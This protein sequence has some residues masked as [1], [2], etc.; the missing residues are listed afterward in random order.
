MINVT[1]LFVS[2][3]VT[4]IGSPLIGLLV[5]RYLG[6]HTY[7]QYASAVAVT[8][9]FGFICD[10]GVQQT[11]L[12]FGANAEFLGPVLK[13]GS[14]VS[15]VYTAITIAI[16]LLWMSIFPYDPLVKQIIA[17]QC[18]GL[19]R[20]PLLTL[21]TAGL[22]LKGKYGRIAFWN[23]STT[24]VQWAGTLATM[25]AGQSVIVL[26][27]I[28]IA[29]SIFLVLIMVVIE[30]R[31]LG[32]F[33]HPGL[34]PDAVSFLR[35]SWK[36]GTAG[37]MFQ[38]Y[39]K[40]DSAIL[41]AARPPLE[42]GQYSVA[43]RMAEMA[44]VI[45]GIVFNQVLYPK[46]FRWSQRD[47]E[48][49]RTFYRLT[50][51][52]IVILGVNVAAVMILFGRDLVRVLFRMDD[53]VI[54]VI[55]PT[56]ATGVMLHF[57]AAAPGAILTTDGHVGRKIWIQGSTAFMSLLLNLLLTPSFGA[58]AAAGVFA[59]SQL[60]L[61]VLYTR[62]LIRRTSF[63]VFDMRWRSIAFMAFVVGLL[64][65]GWTLLGMSWLVRGLSVV[66][67][68]SMSALTVWFIW[69]TEVERTEIRGFL[70]RPLRKWS[71]PRV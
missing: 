55:I 47:R 22:Q 35:E 61:G 41:S 8:G 37:A 58:V 5:V 56:L 2:R 69:L 1:L 42:I 21:V 50:T 30:G 14:L 17:I 70:W 71:A 29:I 62:E 7:G 52:L 60:M 26:T 44:N 27:S 6:P 64:L 67:I 57:W 48:K 59:L 15:L 33:E 23:L 12:R 28:P 24:L 43:M 40:G 39:Q 54:S 36:F 16:V 18:V 20:T 13:R 49:L 51:K 34:S 53:R 66:V 63:L 10:F 31:R 9:L 4:L 38:I 25:A 3:F 68:T 32:V 65:I 45:P 19:I 46:Y 11:V